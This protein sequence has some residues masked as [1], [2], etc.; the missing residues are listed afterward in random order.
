MSTKYPQ[1]FFPEVLCAQ[2]DFTLPPL[3]PR[4]ENSGRFSIKYGFGKETEKPITENGIPPYR[5][6]F[7]GVFNALSQ[8]IVW[9]QRGG[10]YNYSTAMDYEV[11]NEI[12]HNG[13]KWRCA[14]ENGAGSSVIVPGTN[15]AYWREVNG[16]RINGEVVSFVNCRLGGSDGRRLIPW[17][18]TEALENWIFCDGGTDGRGGRVPDLRNRCAVGSTSAD[19]GALGGGVSFTTSTNPVGEV[20]LMAGSMEDPHGEFV[21]LQAPINLSASNYPD[22]YRVLGKSWGGAGRT[23]DLRGRYVKMSGESGNGED[24]LGY[25]GNAGL[26]NITGQFTASPGGY[27]AQRIGTGAFNGDVKYNAGLRQ[28]N[29]DNWGTTYDFNAARSSGIYGAS[30]TVTPKHAVLNAY[31]RVKKS[32]VASNTA[33]TTTT[34]SLAFFVKIPD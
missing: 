12:N 31:L 21:S 14:K 4:L 7:N 1:Y 24:R 8:H 34:Y 26:P 10:V 33:T 20:V 19:S 5:D 9:L 11:G 13:K 29:S 22:A 6:D 16:N 27:P 15:K 28:G 3:E 18:E 25:L 32:V 23:P 17:G 2:G 30:N